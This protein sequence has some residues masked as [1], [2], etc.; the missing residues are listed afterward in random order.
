MAAATEKGDPHGGSEKW[1]KGQWGSQGQDPALYF[2][3]MTETHPHPN[4]TIALP[5]SQLWLYT[6]LSTQFGHYHPE[7]TWL[8]HCNGRYFP[9]EKSLW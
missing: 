2:L 1:N 9:F 6:G 5:Q 7:E 8:T 3:S 4:N